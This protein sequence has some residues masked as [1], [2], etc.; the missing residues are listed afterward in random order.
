MMT[1]P[2]KR[3]VLVGPPRCRKDAEKKR[4][5]G[6]KTNQHQVGEEEKLCFQQRC[7]EVIQQGKEVQKVEEK[8]DFCIPVVSIILAQ[9][10]V[11]ELKELLGQ[12]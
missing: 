4:H 7:Q 9:S 10:C 8:E 3:V 12:R 2:H 11:Q 6:S 5:V 1:A